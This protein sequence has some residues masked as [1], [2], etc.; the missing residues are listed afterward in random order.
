MAD[1]I[2]TTPAASQDSA[3]GGVVT[4]IIIAAIAI[5]AVVL[6]QSGAFQ[7]M[8]AKTDAT[9]INVSIPAP[10]PTPAPTA[11]PGAIPAPTTG[12]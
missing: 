8:P 5:G 9:N 3:L 12:N 11:T 2:I 10:T 7:A 4:A 6:Y 1:T